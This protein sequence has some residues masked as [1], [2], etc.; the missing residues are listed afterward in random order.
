MQLTLRSQMIAGVA[1]LGVSAIAVAPVV[2]PELVPATQRL[3]S[4][5]NLV[6]FDNP[7]AVVLGTVDDLAFNIFDQAAVPAPKDLYWPDSFY[8]KDLSFLFAPG[9]WGGIPDLVNQFST[10]ALSAVVSNVSG[11]L[12][13]ASY[14]LTGLISGSTSAVWN[15]PFALVTAA[16]YLAAGNTAA[17]LA[18]LQTQIVAPL[19]QSVTDVVQ[20]VGY[21][22]DNSIANVGTVLA[23]TIPT[24]LSN[25][26]GTVVSGTTYVLQSALTTLSGVVTNLVALKFQD[27]WNGAV[28]GLLGVDGTLGQIQNLIAG[29]GIIEPVKYTEGTV[30]TVVIPSLRS[31]LTSAS[32]RLGD[33]SSYKEGG[34]RNSAFSPSA[35]A[36][37][38]AV[39]PRAAAAQAEVAAA[40]GEVSHPVAGDTAASSAS[41]VDVA[42]ASTSA[43]APRTE[44]AAP[45]A[46][47]P[48]P[49][50]HKATRRAAATGAEG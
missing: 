43:A 34:I 45:A 39:A 40:T 38:A 33:L 44:G 10:G 19:M 23:N 17:A 42:A 16:G 21:I 15:T 29:V 35:A 2:Q 18:E 30:D 48:T 32:Q 49:A 22:V 50:K 6:A 28:N 1:A 26:I 27:A 36:S 24:L 41:S 46:E 4:A 25:M 37:A 8:T 11:Y 5:V 20:A 47:K 7:I 13:A 12:S 3:S 14:G 31:D 9:Y